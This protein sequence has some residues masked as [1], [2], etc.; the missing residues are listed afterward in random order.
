MASV[1]DIPQCE[2]CGWARYLRGM[3]QVALA[4]LFNVGLNAFFKLAGES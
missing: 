2:D 4:A 1:D 3:I